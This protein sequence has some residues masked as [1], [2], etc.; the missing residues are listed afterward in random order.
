MT[1]MLTYYRRWMTRLNTLF[2]FIPC[3]LLMLA[4]VPVSPAYS[5]TSGRQVVDTEAIKSEAVDLISRL[6]RV[7]QQLFYPVHTRVSVF[8]SVVENS[9]PS[10]HSVSLKI[11]GNRVTDHIYTAKE[12]LAL[13]TGGI[14]RLYTGNIL[15]GKHKLQAS[16]KQVQKDGKV[17]THELEYKFTKDDDAENI[18]IMFDNDKPRIM[19]PSRN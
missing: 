7:E 16:I 5:D 15:M 3:L 8:L 18:E 19:V 1:L 14:Q 4:L 11:D 17:R 12:I 10:L 6:H 2:I 9:Q 13:D